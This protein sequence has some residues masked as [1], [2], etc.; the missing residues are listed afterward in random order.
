MEDERGR[1][2]DQG[3]IVAVPA[4]PC[5]VVSLVPSLTE[6][7]ASVDPGVL[8]GATDYCVEPA[9]LSVE[10]VGGS[11]YPSVEAVLA[12]APDLVLANV[13]ENRLED[14]SAIRAAGVP[15]WV[16]YPQTVDDALVS[17]GRMFTAMSLPVPAWLGE[18]ERAWSVPF[19]T[20]ARRALVPV[21]RRPWV[22]LGSETFAGD[23]LRRLG[24]ATLY[25]DAPDRYPRPSLD[26]LRATSPDLLVL[27]DEP[28]AFTANDGPEAFPGVPFALV[29]GRHLTWYGPSLAEAPA[30]LS[31][32]LAAAGGQDRVVR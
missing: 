14:V 31:A 6:A 26:D 18:A 20:V 12:L 13:E 24:V 4:S 2:D 15:V 30:V 32:Q 9:S 3:S 19:P 27:P 21:W 5:R 8:V 28:Y 17:L 25:A 16:T 1:R 11:K 7:V 10:R 23:V 22:V 29:S